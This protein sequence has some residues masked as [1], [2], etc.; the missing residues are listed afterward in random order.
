[1]ILV[2]SATRIPRANSQRGRASRQSW[3][4]HPAGAVEDILPGKA[5]EYFIG[6]VHWLDALTPPLEAH[7]KSLAGTIK[8][9]LARMEPR[10]A[11]PHPPEPCLW[12]Q[13]TRACCSAKGGTSI[14][15][16]SK[17]SPPARWPLIDRRGCPYF[18]PEIAAIVAAR[19]RRSLAGAASRRSH[20]RAINRTATGRGFRVLGRIGRP[21]SG[22]IRKKFP[23]MA[24]QRQDGP[25]LRMVPAWRGRALLLALLLIAVLAASIT[26]RIRLRQPP[27]PKLAAPMAPDRTNPP[28]FTAELPTAL[29]EYGRPDLR[30]ADGPCCR[31]SLDGPGHPADVDKEGQRRQLNW[32]TSE[33]YCL[34][35]RLAGYSNWRLPTIS[36]LSGIAVVS[37]STTRK[38]ICNLRELRV[39]QSPGGPG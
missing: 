16:R 35:M 12:R 36:E 26:V 19:P 31:R 22:T 38:A 21:R 29:A 6:N 23:G 14:S 20:V 30:R 10:E 32:A 9:L 3:R 28:L 7:L 13:P 39:S 24:V 18:G 27:P 8:M 33:A 25:E 5:L 2:F 1:M 11:P 15:T 37:A 34:D 4:R 17:G